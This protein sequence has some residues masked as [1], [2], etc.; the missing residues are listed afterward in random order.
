MLYVD[1][2]PHH[3]L[4]SF[5]IRPRQGCGVSVVLL[6][7]RQGGCDL[8]DGQRCSRKVIA[9]AAVLLKC[10]CCCKTLAQRMSCGRYSVR[11]VSFVAWCVWRQGGCDQLDGLQW[12]SL[13]SKQ[14][15]LATN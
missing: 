4:D 3:L 1:G 2:S 12:S 11:L 9:A 8:G 15:Y 6:C 5:E 10:C 7:V 13:K 14:D